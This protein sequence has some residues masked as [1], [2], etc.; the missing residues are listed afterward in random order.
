MPANN[1]GSVS[2]QENADILAYI[3]SYNKYPAGKDELPRETQILNQI[4]IDAPKAG[5]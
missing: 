5:H 4:R 1:P 3:L 2:R